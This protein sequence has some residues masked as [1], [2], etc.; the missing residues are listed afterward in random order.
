MHGWT[1]PTPKNWQRID[2]T[3]NAEGHVKNTVIAEWPRQDIFRR[4][5]TTIFLRTSAMRMRFVCRT[6]PEC[7]TEEC[8][9]RCKPDAV[10]ASGLRCNRP[11][12]RL[13][14]SFLRRLPG[15]RDD[16][17]H[18][19]GGCV[20]QEQALLLVR[21]SGLSAC[22]VHL[23]LFPT[24]KMTMKK[25]RAIKDRSDIYS[26]SCAVFKQATTA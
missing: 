17:L 3:R 10:S 21:A 5:A 15:V 26:F 25:K 24:P 23:I 19:A 6:L 12:T 20:L 9:V 14:T 11:A 8:V 4:Q 22:A 2:L 13:N 16:F 18:C 1:A 7:E